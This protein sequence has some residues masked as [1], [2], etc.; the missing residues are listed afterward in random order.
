VLIKR[1]IHLNPVRVG[2]LDSEVMRAEEI[3]KDNLLQS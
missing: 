2:R 3:R 1:Y